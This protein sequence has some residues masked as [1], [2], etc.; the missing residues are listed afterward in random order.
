MSADATAKFWPE[1]MGKTEWNYKD[2]TSQNFDSNTLYITENDWENRKISLYDY[3]KNFIY[4]YPYYGRT[5]NP[6]E[7]RVSTDGNK[8]AADFYRGRHLER[9]S[10]VYLTPKGVYEWSKTPSAPKYNF[11]PEELKSLKI[12]AVRPHDTQVGE[13]MKAP[14]SAPVTEPKGAFNQK[15]NVI[16]NVDLVA[17]NISLADFPDEEGQVREWIQNVYSGYPAVITAVKQLM[18]GHKFKGNAVPLTIINANVLQLQGRETSQ[19]IVD[20][21]MIDRNSLKEALYLSWKEKNSGSILVSFE[22]IIE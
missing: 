6:K 22:D 4:S 14:T 3:S 8:I 2:E 16:L 20:V 1:I 13:F 7:I 10:L 21:S 12:Y 9:E 5:V 11:S 18:D 15:S 19:P 17:L